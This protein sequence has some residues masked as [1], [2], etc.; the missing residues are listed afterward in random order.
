M[1]S[2]ENRRGLIVERRVLGDSLG[3]NHRRSTNDSNSLKLGILDL[4]PKP[5]L[6][7]IS[8][9]ITSLLVVQS[10]AT[11]RLSLFF[12]ISMRKE[13]RCCS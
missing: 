12:L 1:R 7:P 3:P 4:P 8:H 11:T 2:R 5:L 13:S 9:E 6:Q 10:V